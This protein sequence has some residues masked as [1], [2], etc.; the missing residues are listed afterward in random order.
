MK[1]ITP[2]KLCLFVILA[3]CSL[4]FLSCKKEKDPAKNISGDY[5][6]VTTARTITAAPSYWDT[7]VYFEGSISEISKNKVKIIYAEPYFS[8]KFRIDGI[9]SPEIND[10]MSFS[11]SDFIHSKDDFCSGKV[12]DN[13]DIQITF[14]SG[15]MGLNWENIINGTKH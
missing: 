4:N 15:S 11:Y 10:D 12:L 5:L 2:L 8:D 1:I 7:V 14:G 6:F 13:G 9:I 3:V